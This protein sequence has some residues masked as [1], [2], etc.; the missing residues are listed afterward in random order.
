[1]TNEQIRERCDQVLEQMMSFRFPISTVEG[2]ELYARN[3]QTLE[4][5]YREAMA[6]A[7]RE[8]WEH[9]DHYYS[10]EIHADMDEHPDKFVTW[11]RQQKEHS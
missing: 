6:T 9:V 1:M 5:L 7:K 4:S 10:H 11:V 3:A 2:E 8:V